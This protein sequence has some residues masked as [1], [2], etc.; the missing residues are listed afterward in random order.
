MGAEVRFQ[1]GNI[2]GSHVAIISNVTMLVICY[3]PAFDAECAIIS[4]AFHRATGNPGYVACRK[5]REYLGGICW[6]VSFLTPNPESLGVGKAFDV[7]I[8]AALKLQA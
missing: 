2:D 7:E 5:N 3:F 1:L 8:A 6:W 4:S